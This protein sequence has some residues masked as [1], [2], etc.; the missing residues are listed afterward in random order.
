MI[1]VIYRLSGS[2]K[3]EQRPSFYNKSICLKSLLTSIDYYRQRKGFCNIIFIIDGEI[4][5]KITDIIRR[6][7]HKKILSI[8]TKD[9]AGSFWKAFE[10]ATNFKNSDFIYFCED[11]YI[12]KE[13]AISKLAE[14]LLVKSKD[15]ITLYDHP[16][17]YVKEY[18]YGLDIPHRA[19]EV[20]IAQNHHW[21][22]QESTCMT[23]G[24]QVRTLKEDKIIFER[25]VPAQGVPNDRE[26]FRRLQGLLGYEDDSPRR[27]LYGPIPALATHCH[28]DWL[29]PI[30]NWERE[31]QKYSD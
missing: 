13:D 27:I 2:E 4:D 15:Y 30:V 22:T 9:N 24:A 18:K 14:A 6:L 12:H 31:A 3:I 20:F 5:K 23:F 1:H 21:H 25:Y 16:V 7:E 26:L 19:P 8:N 10:I 17:R 11:D 28:K 29:A